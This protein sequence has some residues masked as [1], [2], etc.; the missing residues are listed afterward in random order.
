MRVVMFLVAG[1]GIASA[2][3]QELQIHW[4]DTVNNFSVGLS[5]SNSTYALEKPILVTVHL[6]NDAQ[7][8]RTTPAIPPRYLLSFVAADTLGN[9]VEPKKMDEYDGSV[10]SWELGPGQMRTETVD[11]RDFLFLTNDGT[12]AITARRL[13]GWPNFGISGNAVIEVGT[14]N[15]TPRGMSNRSP[16]SSVPIARPTVATAKTTNR[17]SASLNVNAAVVASPAVVSTAGAALPLASNSPVNDRRPFSS[18]QKI[19][20]GIIAGLLA[21]LLAILWR[22]SRRKPGA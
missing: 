1:I 14:T 10:T 9:Q 12:F 16:T 20:A 2:L 5:V 13:L 17:N 4:G 8:A 19:G 11:L 22:A 6:R 7:V 3:A 15:A 18:G 21:V